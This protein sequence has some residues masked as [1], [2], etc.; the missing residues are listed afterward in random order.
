VPNLSP[1]G[2]T[3]AAAATT[4]AGYL[5]PQYVTP[6]PSTPALP[7]QISNSVSLHSGILRY[8]IF[9]KF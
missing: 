1:A 2:A 7:F 3:T 4:A 9:T 8:V 6:V 5:S